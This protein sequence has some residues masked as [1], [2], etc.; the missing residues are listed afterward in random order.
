MF[1]EMGTKVVNCFPCIYNTGG[2][3]ISST[4]SRNSWIM[5]NQ[6]LRALHWCASIPPAC[7]GRLMSVFP[8]DNSPTAWV[9]PPET[10]KKP[11]KHDKER[12]S[13]RCQMLSS[14]KLGSHFLF[15]FFF[16]LLSRRRLSFSCAIETQMII[17]SV[18]PTRPSPL[19]RLPLLL[20]MCSR[21]F[22]SHFSHFA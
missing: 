5:T 8:S 18:F 15:L 7:Y 21:L 19:R 10:N 3:C 13:D 12:V 14:P 11:K 22:L 20:P 4:I 9:I 2:H 6:V 17:P 16:L 1:Y